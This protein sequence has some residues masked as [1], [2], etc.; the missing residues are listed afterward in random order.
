M[1]LLNVSKYLHMSS[2]AVM[3]VDEGPCLNALLVLDVEEFLICLVGTR[4]PVLTMMEWQ[5]M[6]TLKTLKRN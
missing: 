2:A 3:R 6:F 4:I 1:L 5:F